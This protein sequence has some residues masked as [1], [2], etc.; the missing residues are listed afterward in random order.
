MSK[1]TK[2]LSPAVEHSAIGICTLAPDRPR[3]D[4]GVC[5]ACIEQGL[6]DALM[7]AET[8]RVRLTWTETDTYEATGEL[9]ARRM[10]AL[11][12][13]PA[14]TQSIAL[15]LKAADDFDGDDW[16]SWHSEFSDGASRVDGEPTV[17]ESVRIEPQP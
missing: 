16:Y 13:D 10:R 6:F 11:G 1:V 9:D 12:Y 17:L 14:V 2:P 8:V 4:V 3:A 15:Y 7:P 5:R